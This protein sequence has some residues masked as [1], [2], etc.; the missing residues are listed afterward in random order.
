MA[1]YS[2]SKLNTFR[3]CPLQ[4]RFKYIDRVKIDIGPSI[5]AFMG[6]RVHDALEWLYDQVRNSRVPKQAEVL[7]VYQGFWDGEWTDDV[8]V[9][10][11]DLEAADYRKVGEQCLRTYYARKTPF[12][13]GIVLG[14]EEGFRIRL[15]QGILLNG[16]ID[17]LMK[18]DGNIYE[19]HDYKTSQRLPTPEAAQADEQGGWYALAASERFPQA[20]EVRLVWHYLRHDEELV[21]TR[22]EDELERL[23]ADIADRVRMVEAETVFPAQE[24]PLCSWCDYCAICPAKGHRI[25]VKSLPPNEYIG[26]EGVVLVNRLAELKEKLKDQSEAIQKEITQVEEALLQYAQEN[27]YSLVVGDEKEA[28]I[29]IQD[30]VSLPNKSDPRRDE[31]DATVRQLGLWDEYSDLNTHKL[32]KALQEGAVL[33][34][35][36]AALEAFE[37]SEERTSIRLRKRSS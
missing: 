22:T 25:A 13:E 4:Y 28:A 8:R 16:Y 12:D 14:L 34:S 11:K 31:L 5:E 18:T 29:D 3:T 23:R 10:K 6:S 7:N 15:E 37:K 33:D 26:E 1:Q 17:R 32:R 19:V 24:S 9:I 27:G 2:Y 20:S 21:T 35:H 36:R 30:V